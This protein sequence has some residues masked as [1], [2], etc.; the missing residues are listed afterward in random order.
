MN[1]NTDKG[2]TMTTTEIRDI[3]IAYTKNVVSYYRSTSAGRWEQANDYSLDARLL[4]H[5]LHTAVGSEFAA[6]LLT[7]CRDEAMHLV[8]FPTY[9]ETCGHWVAGGDCGFDPAKGLRVGV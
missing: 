3:A 1:T 6:A 4:S 9:A 5:T 2:H 7:Y 8:D